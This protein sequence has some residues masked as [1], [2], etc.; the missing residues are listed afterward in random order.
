MAGMFQK[1][2]KKKAKLRLAITGPSGG[3]KTWTALS[4]ARKLAG[5]E[6]RIAVIDTERDSA[7]LYSDRFDFD[8]AALAPPFDPARCIEAIKNALE[9]GYDVIV[10]DSGSHFWEGEGG[11]QEIVDNAATRSFGGN[12]WSGWAVG[13]PAYRHLID[14]ILGA[15]A[16]VIMTMRSKTEWVEGEGRTGRKTYQRVGTAPVMRA[17]IEY[18]FTLVADMDLEHNLTISKTRCDELADRVFHKHREGDMAEVLLAWLNSGVDVASQGDIEAIVEAL[19]G[20]AN[21]DARKEAKWAF[22]QAFG[23][24]DT[25]AASRV[26]E[27]LGWISEQMRQ[28]GLGA[29]TAASSGAESAPSEPEAADVTPEQTFEDDP[30]RVIRCLDPVLAG[31]GASTDN[32]VGAG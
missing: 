32:D 6:G 24:P 5:P 1:A 17:G 16:H 11:V 7:C 4:I 31:V 25:I 19:S 26:P 29:P 21:P 20:I 22:V 9:A 15:S 27:A 18:E 2:T 30:G 23:R 12:R 3:G 8:V 14:T 28:Q 10:I 13:T